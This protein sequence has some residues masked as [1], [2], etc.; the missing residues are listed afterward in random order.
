MPEYRC[1]SP[2]APPH[3]EHGSPFRP[4]CAWH[5]DHQLAPILW[6][7]KL[8][9]F[10]RHCFI[11]NVEAEGS[12]V[13]GMLERLNLSQ[14]EF[15]RDHDRHIILRFDWLEHMLRQVASVWHDT[16]AFR[17]RY[18]EQQVAYMVY[19]DGSIKATSNYEPGKDR[20]WR[21]RLRRWFLRG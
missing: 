8:Q 18:H 12:W 16:R 6:C 9:E 19:P 14:T 21:R 2:D 17:R 3:T 11:L 20:T 4:L 1:S 5:R 7:A 10:S 15:E 13:P